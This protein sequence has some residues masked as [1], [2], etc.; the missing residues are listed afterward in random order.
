V[1]AALS[2]RLERR[3]LEAARRPGVPTP[4]RLRALS[5]LIAAAAI[6][7]TLVGAGALVAGEVT[8]LNIHQRTVPAIVGMQRIHAWLAD[9][10]RSAANAYLAG[11][12]EVTLPELQYQADIAAASRELQVASEHNP[13]GGD[14]SRRLQGIAMAVSQYVSVVQTAMVDDRLG[15]AVGTVYLN[16]GTSLMHRPDTG[17]LA[18]VDALRTLYEHDLDQANRTRQ[19]TQWLL[20]AY[21][22][23]AVALLALLALTQRFVRRRFRRRQNGRL[24]AATLLLLVMAAATAVGAVQARQSSH[25]ASDHA[26]SRLGGLWSARALLYDAN[27]NESLSL[28]AR[29][30]AGRAAADQAFQGETRRLVDRPLTD[31]L[32]RD[33][34][35]GRVRF[36]GMLA[37]QLRAATTAAERSAVLR[38]LVLYRKFLEVDATVRARA[39]RGDAAG[40]VGLALGTDQGQLTFAFADVDWYLG[41]AI[42]DLQGQFDDAMESAERSIG[43][44]AGVEVVGLV[45]AALALWGLQPRIAEFAVGG[46]RR[47]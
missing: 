40:A 34:T 44:T 8:M 17:I 20:V 19:V 18:Q 9:A 7:L 27:G 11:G 32:V 12:S 21:A 33:A 41:V 35:V 1:N 36:G 6:T 42:D 3:V 16:A 43:I 28:I 29:D 25:V 22:A 4:R 14:T 31:D 15:L 2:P 24:L 23:I 5:V 13:G 26:Y 39:A 10:D 37:D 45:V 47:A 46:P 30:E 38:V